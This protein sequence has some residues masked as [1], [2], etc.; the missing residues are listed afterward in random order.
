VASDE[1]PKFESVLP[2][3]NST[4]TS[5]CTSSC[6]CRHC[7]FRNCYWA[8]ADSAR[9]LPV[10][11]HLGLSCCRVQTPLPCTA[12]S[13]RRQ[14][15]V[16]SGRLATLV[17]ASVTMSMHGIQALMRHCRVLQ[18]HCRTQLCRTV[19]IHASSSKRPLCSRTAAAASARD[20]EL[21]IPGGTPAGQQQV[22]DA[23]AAALCSACQSL[24]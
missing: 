6:S 15:H 1:Q 16:Q 19:V 20:V 9:H 11:W 18:H 8:F 4:G 5:I 24:C 14:T 2:A 22:R 3:T 23:A 12:S 10:T 7:N 13:E 17:R 21:L